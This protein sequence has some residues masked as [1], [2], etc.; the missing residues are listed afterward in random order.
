M[1]NEQLRAFQHCLC[2]RSFAATAI[3]NDQIKDLEKFEK[4]LEEIKAGLVI[5]VM[6]WKV[7]RKP[8][9]QGMKNRQ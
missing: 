8:E 3:I 7:M 1:V 4:F 2:K 5:Y 9:I 6:K